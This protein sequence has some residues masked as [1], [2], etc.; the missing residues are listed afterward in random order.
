MWLL[1]TGSLSAFAQT[2]VSGRVTDGEGNGMPGVNVV[3]KGTSAGTSTDATGHYSLSV[4][5]G[6][7]LVFSFI[8]YGTQEVAVGGRSTV[9]VT[10]TEDTRQLGEV[11]V[12]ALGVE[13]ET[14]A[15]GYS[16][17]QV[18]GE[19]FQEARTNNLGSQLTGR[20]AGVNATTSASGPAGSTRVI[21]RGNKSLLG[22]N[23]PLYVVDGI[24]MDNS[25]FGNA[26]LWGGADEGDGMTSI[27]PDDIESI[28][29]LKGAN[30]A[31]L[32]GARAANGVINIITKSGTARKGLG[33][34]FSSNFVFEKLN[35][36][37]DYQKE[38]GEGDYVRSNPLDNNSP[39][40]AV[41]PRNQQEGMNWDEQMWGPRLGSG[42]FVAFDGV[43]RPYVDAGDN[44]KRFF[45]TGYNFTN[46]LALS[47]GNETQNFRISLSD[48]KNTSIV[49]N[50]GFDR[51]TATLS[52]NSKFGK[53]LTFT[54]KIFYSHEFADNRTNL[55]DSP[56]N[57]H[58]SM[59]YVPTNVNVDWFKGDPNKLGAV[60]LDQDATSL[61]IWGVQPGWE[62]PAGSQGDLWHQNPWFVAYQDDNDDT[63]DRIIGSGQARYQITDWLWLQGRV[64]MDWYTR[65]KHNVGAEGTQHNPAGGVTEEEQR[66]REINVDWMAGADKTFGKF[67]INAFVGGQTM[68]HESERLTL[69]GS[70]FSVPFFQVI[71]NT[72]GR[73]WG[74]GYS[75]S[76]INSLFGSATF[77]YNDILFLTA[78]GRQDWFSVLN[79]ET[80]SVFYPSVGGSFVF[81]DAFELPSFFSFGKLRASWA[82]AGNVTIGAYETNLTYSLNGDTHLGYTMASF[83]SAGGQGGTIPNPNL[84]PLVSTELEFGLDMRFLDGRVGADLTYYSQR[85]TK[86]ILNATISRASGFQYT[87]VN[88]GEMS[89]KGIEV[90]LTGT[91]V[92]GAFTWDVSL[93]L[94]KNANKVVSLIEG[95][96][97]LLI[98]EP[99]SRNVF[100]KH[101]VGHPF[102][103]ITGRVQKL[104]PDGQPVFLSSGRPV[105]EDGYAILGNGVPDLTGG[106]MNTFTYKGVSLSALIDFKFGGDMFSGT[107]NRLTQAGFTKMSLQGREG[108]E[109]LVVKGVIQSVDGNGAPVVDENGDPVYE[110]FEKTLTPQ[111]ASNY[112]GDVGGETNAKTDL[113]MYDASFIKLRQVTL[114]YSLPHGILTKTP[115]RNVTVS[116]IGRNLAIIHKNVPNIDPESGYSN[117][118]GQGLEYFGFPAT[119]S[120]GFDLKLQF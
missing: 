50:T 59:Y 81:S 17:T 105:Q 34:D 98:E 13:R 78:T 66:I 84:V 46:T 74:Y 25:Q 8:G 120:Y 36:L 6:A 2:A 102:G 35:D 118:N 107:N 119:R 77:G 93:N 30:A 111:E 64:G 22:N 52:T 108:E 76:G 3:V 72:E 41:A 116:F 32:Y 67:A 68:R 49:P 37:R 100:I 48:L 44:F 113:F 33:I 11:V 85:T 20:I 109:P 112:W 94:A 19:A 38:F 24:P 75:K 55:S 103:E 87:S 115:L 70:G 18:Q 56:N 1:V 53:K 63:R 79:P 62:V 10:M 83:S 58:L 86:D 99:R 73:T 4:A 65:R 12:T 45:Q 16:V 40:I 23:Q 15:L 90:L 14:K 80:N 21:I 106:F 60:P 96:D 42:T 110:P 114:A 31:A 29:V 95:N 88:L 91:P 89:N 54:S 104:S 97:E 92:M 5:D 28:T 7:T 47:G 61:Q 69:N 27:N 9:D 39:Y 43:E 26:G 117:G 71:N 101:I 51:T 57:A 82:R